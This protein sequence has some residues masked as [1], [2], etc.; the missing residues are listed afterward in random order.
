[1]VRSVIGYSGTVI[2]DAAQP[3]GMPQKLLDVSVLNSLGWKPGISLLEGI[4]RT[5]QAYLK[6]VDIP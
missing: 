3:D 4:Q 6:A 5:Y 1:M 2:W